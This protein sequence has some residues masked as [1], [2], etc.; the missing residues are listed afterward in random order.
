MA[1]YETSDF[2]WSVTAPILP[3]KSRGVRGVDAR[4]VFE[5]DYFRD[6][7]RPWLA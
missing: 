7:E 4:R 2:E 3:Q 6:Q 5:R 1:R